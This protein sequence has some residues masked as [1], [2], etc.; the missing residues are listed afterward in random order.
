M[1]VVASIGLPNQ[2]PCRV[3]MRMDTAAN[4]G[5]EIGMNLHAHQTKYSTQSSSEEKKQSIRDSESNDVVDGI[6]FW[7]IS[8]DWIEK[9]L[10][11]CEFNGD[12]I[13][14]IISAG[15]RTIL[16]C[17]RVVIQSFSQSLETRFCTAVLF[18]SSYS[19][20]DNEKWL[21]HR[22]GR[23]GDEWVSGQTD[24]QTIRATENVIP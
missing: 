1:N 12:R 5:M 2:F 15:R 4:F 24:R 7:S 14:A 9:K 16:D 22:G 13:A 20:Q 18:S 19:W 10:T 8:S 23:G 21:F 3:W 17:R 6:R 11:M